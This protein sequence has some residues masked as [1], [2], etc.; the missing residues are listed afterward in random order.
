MQRLAVAE[1]A[2]PA[3]P[4]EEARRIL[5]TLDFERFFWLACGDVERFAGLLRAMS[6]LAAGASLAA[7][8]P[9]LGDGRRPRRLAALGVAPTVGGSTKEARYVSKGGTLA[10]AASA[11]RMVRWS[12]RLAGVLSSARSSPTGLTGVMERTFLNSV[13]LFFNSVILLYDGLKIV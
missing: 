6:W 3:E 2:L 13:I 7:A 4:P 8:A 10:A 9:W 5:L 12:F 1:P 11:H